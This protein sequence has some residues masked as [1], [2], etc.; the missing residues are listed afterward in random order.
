MSD[1]EAAAW[2]SSTQ[3]RIADAKGRA[4]AALDEIRAAQAG[5]RKP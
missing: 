4:L 3:A 5:R 1:S 2:L